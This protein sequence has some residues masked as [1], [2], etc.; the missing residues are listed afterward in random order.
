MRKKTKI[1]WLNTNIVFQQFII[2]YFNH[3][4]LNDQRIP[5]HIIVDSTSNIYKAA[6]AQVNLIYLVCSAYVLYY[7][8]DYIFQKIYKRSNRD[9]KIQ[10]MV[11]LS[12]LKDICTE[13]ICSP[14]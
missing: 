6:R 11:K 1:K 8:I 9:A 4:S 14:H 7:K 13:A 10:C 12:K 3:C 2:N 5:M